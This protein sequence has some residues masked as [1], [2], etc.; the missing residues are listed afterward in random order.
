[1]NLR[2]GIR[3]PILIV[4]SENAL[5]ALSVDEEGGRQVRYCKDPEVGF[6]RRLSTG[7]LSIFAPESML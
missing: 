6:W 2:T 5:E 4:V 7:C 1:M 3:N